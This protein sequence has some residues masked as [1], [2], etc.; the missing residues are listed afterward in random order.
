GRYQRAR[1]EEVMLMLA[2]TDGL[3]R[4]FASDLTPL[5]TI[6]DLGLNLLDRLPVIKNKLI[7]HAMGK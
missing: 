4:L 5:R 7:A 3:A 1:K 6:R 2:T